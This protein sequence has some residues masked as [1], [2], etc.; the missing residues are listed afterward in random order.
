MDDGK[1]DVMEILDGMLNGV[2]DGRQ[3]EAIMRFKREMERM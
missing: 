1:E 3:R 2:E